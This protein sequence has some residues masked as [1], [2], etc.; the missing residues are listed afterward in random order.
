MLFFF[1]SLKQEKKQLI[2][3]SFCERGLLF[4]LKEEER[5]EKESYLEIHRFLSQKVFFSSFLFLV[6][7]LLLNC[8][9][10][11]EISIGD[12]HESLL[13]HITQVSFSLLLLS[14]FSLSF[15]LSLSFYSDPFSSFFSF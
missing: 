8:S 12:L 7:F 14:P 2:L 6:S 13:A 1:P 15:F 4:V 5:E 3:S 9:S 10:K 11:K